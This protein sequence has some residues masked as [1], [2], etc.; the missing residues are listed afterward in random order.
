MSPL[1]L[2]F[3]SAVIIVMIDAASRWLGRRGI[4]LL[5]MPRRGSTMQTALAA[6]AVVAVAWLL[7]AA[8]LLNRIVT[9]DAALV[10][11]VGVIIALQIATLLSLALI[12]QR[13]SR[14]S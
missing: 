11:V 6:G 12:V 13:R 5:P 3:T 10:A 14:P 4:A 8:G 2:A 9:S 7:D 1:W